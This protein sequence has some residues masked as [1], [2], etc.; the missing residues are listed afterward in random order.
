[1][2]KKLIHLLEKR[3]QMDKKNKTI[4]MGESIRTKKKWM[5]N[6]TTV[7][8][9]RVRITNKKKLADRAWWAL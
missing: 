8:I 3:Q 1:M 5:N 7:E 2:E 6:Q 9:R 4:N